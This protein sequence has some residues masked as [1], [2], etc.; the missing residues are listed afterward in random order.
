MKSVTIL[1]FDNCHASSVTNFVDV[2]ATANQLWRMEQPEAEPLFRWRLVAAQP[3]RRARRST[4][5]TTITTSSG[6]TLDAAKALPG[7]RSDVVYAPACHF[8]GE[9]RLLKEIDALASHTGDWLRRQQQG[10]AWLVAGC[11]GG[12][13]L[14]RCGLLDGKVVTTSYW[15]AKLFRREFPKAELREGELITE[16]EQLICAGPVGAHG[17]LGLRIVEKCAGKA[18]AL[19]CAKTLLIDPNKPSQRPYVVLQDELRHTDALVV[20]AEEWLKRHLGDEVSMTHLARSVGASQRN[21]NRRFKSAQ[22]ATPVEYLQRLR[23]DAAK[24]LLETTDLGLDDILARIGYQDSAAFRRLFK[25][26][27]SLSP[28]AYRE[29]FAIGRAARRSRRLQA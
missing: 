27:T 22:G 10:G 14:G 8:R 16:G 1:V 9:A 28:R 13:L 20:R 19:R 3:G 26:R 2:L 6:L 21:L 23:I 7:S 12:F 24:N 15:L 25:Q 18:L 29:R 17:N 11:S 4:A 5:T